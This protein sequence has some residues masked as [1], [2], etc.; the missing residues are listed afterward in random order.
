MLNHIY[1][2]ILASLGH[3]ELIN[4]II[5]TLKYN[6]I[7]PQIDNTMELYFLKSLLKEM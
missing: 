6:E 5:F 4:V 7:D 3:S 1:D 2:A